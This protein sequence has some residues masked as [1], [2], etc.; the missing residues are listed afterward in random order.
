MTFGFNDDTT[1]FTGIGGD[2]FVAKLRR[3]MTYSKSAASFLA[4]SDLVA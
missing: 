4:D 2:R 1:G 3:F